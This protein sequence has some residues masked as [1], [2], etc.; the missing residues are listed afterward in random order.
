MGLTKDAENILSRRYYREG[1]DWEKLCRRVANVTAAAEK[2]FVP[3][4]SDSKISDVEESFFTAVYDLKLLPN[5]PALM[6]AGLEN[7]QLAACVVLPIEDDMVSITDAI[8]YAALIHKSG[9]GTGF[10]FSR[11]RPAGDVVV[12]TRGIA[13]GPISFMSCIDYVTGQIKQGGRRRGANMGVLRVDHPDIEDFVKCKQ[14]EGELSNFNISIAVTDQF[15]GDAKKGRL[16][17]LINPRTSVSVGRRN[18]R[19]ILNLI[20]DLAWRNGEPGVFFVDRANERYPSDV[21]IRSTN[22]CGEQILPDYG[23]CALASVNLGKLVVDGEVDWGG[24]EGLVRVGVRFLDNLIEVSY[25]PHPEIEK[26]SKEWRNVGLG[27]MGW[28]DMLLLLGVPYGSKKSFSVAEE[29]GEALAY[30]SLD[31]SCNLAKERG[32]FERFKESYY[33][34]GGWEKS[35]GGLCS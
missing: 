26:F 30:W 27:V 3:D 4:V 16:Y 9:G 23:Q 15:M 21:E 22:P 24:F 20:V 1:E 17:D 5:S 25:Y 28:A 6:N 8:K 32:S 2:V 34:R 29:V 13:S 35:L 31:E 14:R 19:E 12:S 10:D 7:G 18:S 33:H 11:L